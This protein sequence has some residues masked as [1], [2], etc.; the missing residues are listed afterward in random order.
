MTESEKVRILREAVQTAI[1]SVHS[2]DLH[3]LTAALAATAEPAKERAKWPDVSNQDRDA[4]PATR[5]EAA[6]GHDAPCY[7]CQKPCNALAGNPGLWPVGLP[8]ADEPGV[9]K[10]HHQSCVTERLA[11]HRAALLR[12]GEVVKAKV[13]AMK[14]GWT[15]DMDGRLQRDEDGPW[16]LASAIANAIDVAALAEEPS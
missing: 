3:K 12:F 5:D 4:E 10:W 2:D 1:V 11:E 8:H 9:L 16:G 14:P 7:Y 13:R 15:C 6:N